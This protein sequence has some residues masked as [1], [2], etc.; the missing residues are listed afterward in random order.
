MR[1]GEAIGW[2][3]LGPREA[4][5]RLAR[6]RTLPQLPGESVWSVNCFVVA[7]TARRTGVATTLLAAAVAYG[8]AHGARIVEGYPVATGGTRIPSASVYTGS[9]SMFEATGFAKAADSTSKAATGPPRV[10]MRRE[11]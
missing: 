1:D 8:E 6:S 5:P 3:G 2:V 4:F 7:R 10:V 9:A 11:P